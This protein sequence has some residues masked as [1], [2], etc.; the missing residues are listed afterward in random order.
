MK[1]GKIPFVLGFLFAASVA[2]STVHPLGN[3]HKDAQPGA[4]VLQ[5]AEAP[6]RVRA[7]LEQKCGDCHSENTR[8]PLYSHLAPLSWMIDR[9]VREGRESLDMS[10]WQF[11]NTE[12]RI[13]ALTRM[14]SEVHAGQMPPRPYILFHPQARLSTEEQKLIYDWAKSGRKQLRSM[15]S[16]GSDQSSLDSRTQKP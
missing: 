4:P 11:Y 8:Y 15:S 14:A 6:E 10:R 2:L 3:P 5:G 9:D 12:D 7:T 1:V 13:N 16:T